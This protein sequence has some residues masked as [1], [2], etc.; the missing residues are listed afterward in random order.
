MI[1]TTAQLLAVAICGAAL[2][3]TFLVAW[4]S[5]DET[6]I[7]LQAIAVAHWLIYNMV[8]AKFGFDTTGVLM[9]TLSCIAAIWSAWAGFGSRS[10]VALA[11]VVLWIAA[12]ALSTWFYYI[13]NQSAP[14]HYLGLNLTFIARMAVVGLAGVV[15]LVR[16]LGPVPHWAD[17]RRLGR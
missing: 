6:L 14:L 9:V 2:L 7:R 4:A 17:A 15:Q 8:I 5:D 3:S 1:Y 11:V 10:R 16:R 12:A 13:R